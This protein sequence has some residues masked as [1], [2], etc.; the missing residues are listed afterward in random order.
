MQASRIQGVMSQENAYNGSRDTAEKV[1]SSPSKVP[2]II[3]LSKPNSNRL[4]RK[5][6]K[7]EAFSFMNIPQMKVEIKSKMYI[8]SKF[9]LTDRKLTAYTAHAWKMRGIRFHIPSME[10]EI[11]AKM[12]YPLQLKC[13]SLLNDR[14]HIRSV[15]CTCVENS[16]YG[17]SEKSNNG[18]RDTAERVLRS[19]NVMPFIID[20]SQQKLNIFYGTRGK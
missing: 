16:K 8:F 19:P 17:D 5:R 11:Q 18:R 7:S 9:L 3:D 2:F 10:A 12:Y 13:P 6:W 1:P 20:R 15:C 14:N 4:Q